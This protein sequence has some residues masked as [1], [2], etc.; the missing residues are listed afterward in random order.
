MLKF[1]II[2]YLFYSIILIKYIET[3]NVSKSA[4]FL[5]ATISSKLNI[6]MPSRN[7]SET[8]IIPKVLVSERNDSRP[9]NYGLFDDSNGFIETP[10]EDMDISEAIPKPTKSDQQHSVSHFLD[11]GLNFLSEYRSAFNKELNESNS[12]SEARNI[13]IAYSKT[14]G[15]VFEAFIKQMTPKIIESS[16]DTN[17]SL[18]C[19]GALFTMVSGLRKQKD[20]AVKLF[21][22]VGRPLIAGSL[23]G[24]ITSLGAYDQCLSI[25][26]DS[27]ADMPFIGQYCVIKYRISL[28]PKP[29]RLTLRSQVFN[30]TGTPVEGTFLEEFSQFAHAFYDRF[31]RTGICIPSVCGQSDFES[32]LKSFMTESHINLTV[33]DC[34][35]KVL[36][37]LNSLQITILSIFGAILVLVILAT[38]LDLIKVYTKDVIYNP[39]IRIENRFRKLFLSTLLSFS[40]YTNGKQ[41]F[42]T[43]TRSSYSAIECINGI[44]VLSMLWILWTHTYLIPIKETFSFARDF[45]FSVEELAFQLILNGWVLVDTFFLVGAMLTT[46]SHFNRMAKS[47]DRIN[48][49]Q[50]ILNRFFRFWPSVTL[51]VMLVFL[52]P[53]LASGPLWNEYFDLQLDKCYKNW[54]TTLTFINNWFDESQMCLL[55]TWYLSADIQLFILSFAFIIPLYKK[56]SLGIKLIT[57]AAI[58]SFLAIAIRTYLLKQNPTVLYNTPNERTVYDQASTIYVHTYI[59]LGPYCVGLILGYII[60]KY[61]TFKIVSILN[62]FVWFIALFGCLAIMLSTYTLNRGEIWSPAS[63]ALYAGLHRTAWSLCIAWI[64][65]GCTTGNGGPIN[66]FLSWKLFAPLGKLSFMIYLMHFLVIWVR[67]AYL[68]Q[69]LPFSH[70]TMFC[71]FIVNLVISTCVS[72][73]THLSIEA[74]MMS[75]YRIYLSNI[76]KFANIRIIETTAKKSCKQVNDS[77]IVVSSK[78]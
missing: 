57:M 32:I 7:G 45:M 5:S 27:E 64:I 68:R 30:F 74:P 71:E 69:P 76:F 17:M 38:S 63:A 3:Q 48:V 9:E 77:G 59:H 28:P 23:D 11:S 58:A 22:S 65:F 40:L 2:L 67:Y 72:I 50:Q 44:R 35:T 19:M 6:P 60:F 33:N 12:D 37:Q 46:Y 16:A 73:V 15:Q 42:D 20:W 41:L 10:E 21:D 47:D 56:P 1:S 49:L 24:T 61:K 54:W 55:H 52:I 18:E 66:T 75:L 26:T 25:E 78:L 14:W 39:F 13:W 70:Y 8:E 43:T 29:N 62:L 36:P 53:S 34:H 31:G 4:T 51:A